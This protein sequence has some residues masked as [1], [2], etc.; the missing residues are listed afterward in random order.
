MIRLRPLRSREV[1]SIRHWAI[2]LAVVVIGVLLALWAAEWAQDR[3]ARK[4]SQI[5]QDAMDSD[6]MFMALGTM[7]R[8]ST[9]PCVRESIANLE[10]AAATPIGA[11]FTPPPVAKRVER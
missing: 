2:E 8:Y 6:L 5:A 4:S 10:R 3:S 7:R 11:P 9:Q 1:R